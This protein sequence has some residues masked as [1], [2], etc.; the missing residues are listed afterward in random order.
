[1]KAFKKWLFA[2]IYSPFFMA[3]ALL[4]FT[5]FSANGWKGFVLFAVSMAIGLLIDAIGKK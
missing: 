2:D 4:F 1:M 3:W 5:V